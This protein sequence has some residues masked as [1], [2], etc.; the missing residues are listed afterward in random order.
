MSTVIL[1]DA[2]FS[3][4]TWY[5]HPEC[6]DRLDAIMEAIAVSGLAD[7]LRQAAPAEA[8]EAALLAVHTPE[9]L[10]RIRTLSSYG[11]GQIDGDTY[12]T[13]DSWDAAVYA[14]GAAIGA[15]DVALGGRRGNAFALVRP[16]GHHATPGRAMGF[17]LI[18][19][20]AVA[21]RHAIDHYGLGRV[22][23][24]DY[25]VHHGNGT[26][27]IFYDD[28]RVLFISTHAA[29]FYPGTGAMA[30]V[31]AAGPAAGTTLNIPLPFGVG[32]A[33]YAKVFADLVAPALRRF[34]PE[35][36]LVSAGYDSHWK[37]PLG[38]MAL[39]TAGFSHLTA[40]LLGLA[41]ELCAGRV[42]LILEGGY[43]LEA[44]GACAVSSLRLMLGRDPGPDMLGGQPTGGTDPGPQIAMIRQ[45]HPIFLDSL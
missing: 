41:D 17:C 38:P 10:R 20:I 31:G 24:V 36:L 7:D 30:E 39:S 16:P 9:L 18:N 8:P 42:A 11:G 14:A 6:A 43:S 21:A 22:A 40:T 37:D 13:A 32:D 12:V 33:G 45:R 19:N 15:V 4:H 25:D 44:L 35:L 1:S 5:G 27:D 3:A 23:I 34:K 26:Q 28:P 29:P 2:R